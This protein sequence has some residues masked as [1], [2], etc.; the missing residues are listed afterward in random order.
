MTQ[1]MKDGI[2]VHYGEDFYKLIFEPLKS[3]C[4]KNVFQEKVEENI[5]YN[6]INILLHLQLFTDEQKN[7]IK[8]ESAEH[9]EFLQGCIGD[10]NTVI[11]KIL[12][13]A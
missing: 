6:L 4:S 8:D 12:E 3:L 2:N 10:M 1:F 11:L 7:G 5:L 13:N 9:A